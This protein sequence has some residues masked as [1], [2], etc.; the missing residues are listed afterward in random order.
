MNPLIFCEV[1]A[2]Y[3]ITG[4]VQIAPDWMQVDYLTD[5]YRDEFIVISKL[6]YDLCY[7][8]GLE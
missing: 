4:A 6:S 8:E 3:T 5:D 1:L 7:P 2:A